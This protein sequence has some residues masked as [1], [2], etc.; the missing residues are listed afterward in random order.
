[1]ALDFPS[2]PTNGQIYQNW[3]WDGAKWA[4]I[5]SGGT[6]TISGDVTGSGTASIPTTVTRLQTNPVSATAPTTSQV[7][8][9]SGTQWQPATVSVGTG[10]LPLTGGTLTGSLTVNE[11][12]SSAGSNA[13]LVFRDR[14]TGN[15]WG[16]YST[17][18]L[19]RLWYGPV[20]DLF[21]IDTGGNLG[22]G[23]ITP[24]NKLHVDGDIRLNGYSLFFGGSTGG[25]NVTST[26]AIIYGDNATLVLKCPA[27][28]GLWI[29]N[30]NGSNI[31]TIDNGG[32]AVLA[33]G[34]LRA[35]SG[36]ISN[37]PYSLRFMN[38]SAGVGAIW[39]NDGG[40]T[41]LLLTNNNDPYGGFNSLRPFYVNNTSGVVTMAHGLS[42]TNN[43]VTAANFAVPYSQAANTAGTV[44]FLNGQGPRIE[45][46]G[47]STGN[48]GILKFG[49]GSGY[50]LNFQ[51]ATLYPAADNAY[52]CGGSYAWNTVNSYVFAQSSDVALKTNIR[53]A[54][55]ALA[56]VAALTPKTFTWKSGPDTKRTHHGFIAQEV[57]DAL[58]EEFGGYIA[59]KEPGHANLDYSELTAVLWKGVQELVSQMERMTLRLEKLESAL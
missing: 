32:N 43:N 11:T 7:L 16:W 58:G 28:N 27:Q 41:Y 2:G 55:S 4:I 40:S 47:N 19:A 20:G 24:S 53:P 29:Q 57:A 31:F 30:S 3:Q 51:G 52:V 59:A 1:M 50:I 44:G 17:G 38:G 13:L 33:Y 6:I 42:V 37:T 15:S 54:P 14:S 48:P 34:S 49:S 22:V 5:P 56:G 12:I 9:F 35:V 26:G 18:S 45:F 36:L 23:H 10:Y 39:Y 21:Y 25:V 46:W 8:Q